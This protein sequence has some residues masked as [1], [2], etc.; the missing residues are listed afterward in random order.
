[1]AHCSLEGQKTTFLRHFGVQLA[2]S[3]LV[4][5]GSGAT[6]TTVSPA[7]PEA[8]VEQAELSTPALEASTPGPVAMKAHHVGDTAVHRFSGT[9]SKHALIL[10]EE[11]V[12]V[13]TDTF[14]VHYTLDEGATQSEL[15]V[16]R[17]IRSERV[18]FVQRLDHGRKMPGS[19]RDYEALIEK[20]LFTPDQNSGALAR[21]EQTCLVGQAEH[22]CE[23]AEYR[24]YVADQEARLSV[25]RSPKLGRDVSGEVIAVD[26]TMI[27]H[28]ELVEVQE[29]K[30]VAHTDEVAIISPLE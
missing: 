25:M 22:D 19:T 20:T 3:L 12:A 23:V 21:S 28:A 10:K 6:T 1:M 5:C 18:V 7:V 29:G 15:L 16:T 11:V 8:E 30:G 26:G 4:A 17:G 24:V 2:G 9:F 27:Y 14:T 13:S